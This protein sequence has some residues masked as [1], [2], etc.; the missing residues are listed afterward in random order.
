MARVG[1]A[2]IALP[3]LMRKHVFYYVYFFFGKV[4]KLMRANILGN[5]KLPSLIENIVSNFVEDW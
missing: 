3:S 1:K 4:S 5:K 2:L